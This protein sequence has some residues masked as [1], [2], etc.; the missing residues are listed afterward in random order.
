MHFQQLSAF[1]GRSGGIS[2][3]AVVGASNCIGPTSFVSKLRDVPG[4]SVHNRSVGASSSRS[5]LYLI[6]GLPRTRRGVA[7]IDFAIN[8]NDVAYNL[9]GKAN[10]A[11]EV[12][13]QL[14][15]LTTKLVSLNYFPI[16][17][18]LPWQIDDKGVEPGQKIHT[19]FCMRSGVPFLDLRKLFQ[20]LVHS[21]CCD[22][23]AL[24][25]DDFHM[26]ENAAECLAA[27]FRGALK[28]GGTVPRPKGRRGEPPRSRVLG[29]A[30][31]FP[32]DALVVRKTS[33][34][35]AAFG[36]MS[37]GSS[38]SVPVG[39]DEKLAGLMV[40]AGAIGGT[41]RISGRSHSVIKQLNLKWSVQPNRNWAVFVDI[42]GPALGGPDGVRIDVVDSGTSPTETTVHVGK[43]LKDETPRIEIEGF[44]LTAADSNDR[45]VLTLKHALPLDLSTLPA[46]EKLR[47][48]LLSVSNGRGRF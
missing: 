40:N 38:I 16:V 15:D 39:A 2:D 27:F 37:T 44:L 48:E 42:A 41:V 8:D 14:R 47:R 45:G 31:L 22:A 12:S 17:L 21:G 36:A 26:S 24:M 33:H 34:R 1:I 29:A 25:R 19:D 23:A 11:R 20:H 35:G 28:A 4:T 13:G 43:P 9:W 3:V 7:L 46:G 6:D 5:A 18:I 30:D 32:Q 10:A